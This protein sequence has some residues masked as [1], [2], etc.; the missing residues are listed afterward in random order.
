[1][2]LN[3]KGDTMLFPFNFYNFK[4]EFKKVMEKIIVKKESIINATIECS[5]ITEEAYN[6]LLAFVR[7]LE[8]EMNISSDTPIE[9]E[10]AASVVTSEK[11]ERVLTHKESVALLKRVEDL[12]ADYKKNP[13]A[14]ELTRMAARDVVNHFPDFKNLDVRPLGRIL[15]K[16]S[17]KYSIPFDQKYVKSEGEANYYKLRYFAVP[18]PKLSYGTL[19]RKAREEAHL[20]MSEFAEYIGYP[21]TVVKAWEESKSALSDEAKKIVKDTFGHDIFEPLERRRA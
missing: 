11:K 20:S 13:C 14:Y 9:A 8:E 16:M 21:L 15:M 10:K 3:G 12:Y 19:I 7:Q 2:G 5:G 17:E 6:R 18:V 4:K 1:M